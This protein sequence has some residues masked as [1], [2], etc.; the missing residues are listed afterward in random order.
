MTMQQFLVKAEKHRQQN[1][2]AQAAEWYARAL[3]IAPEDKTILDNLAW[4]YSCD[5]QYAE[6]AQLYTRLGEMEPGVAKWPYMLGYQYYAQQKWQ[7]A[8]T[9]F[10]KALSLA[11]GYLAAL[12]RKGYAHTRL[13]EIGKALASFERCRKVW[14]ALP[15]GQAKELNQKFCTDA[16]FQ[17]GK[18]L[19]KQRKAVTSDAV[20]IAEKLLEEAVQR[21]PK[22]VFKHYNLGLA[23]LANGKNEAA[24]RAFRDAERTH[25][26]SSPGQPVPEYIYDKWATALMKLG[27]LDEAERLYHNIPQRQRKAYILRNIGW[28]CYQKNEYTRAVDILRQAIQKEYS[29]HNG[30]Y[31]LGM[32]LAACERW[33]E[34]IRELEEAIRLRQARYQ[35]DFPEATQAL[36]KIREE[37]PNAIAAVKSTKRRRG[38]IVRYNQDRGFGF[39]RDQAGEELFFHVS[40]FRRGDA[41]EVD[42]QVE[43]EWTV[44]EKGPRAV[45]IRTWNS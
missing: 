24:V 42:A 20:A 3:E 23:R 9:H 38:V 45:N 31:F 6:A 21:D 16:A 29:N 2:W 37:H 39:I 25:K 19:L 14:Y 44:A 5:G 35:K 41:I 12:Y 40:N 32:A 26:E 7:K 33:G 11:P 43:Y 30:H 10:E 36:Q 17:Q 34:A 13:Q 1:Q 18:L 28:L 22:D 15:E 4:C 27:Q 8:I